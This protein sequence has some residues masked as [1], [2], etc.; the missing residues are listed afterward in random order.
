MCRRTAS[1]VIGLFLIGLA[2]SPAVAQDVIMTVAGTGVV[3][4]A[5]DGGQATAAQ[6]NSPRGVAVDSAGNVYISDF[7]AHCVRKIDATTGVV[8]TVAGTGVAGYNG[9]GIAA[10]AA[11]LNSPAGM[12]LDGSGNLFIADRGNH[13]IRVVS[14]SSGRIATVAGTGTAGY[15]GDGAVATSKQLYY[16]LGVAVDG[17]G[18][19]YIADFNNHRIRKVTYSTGFIST[20]AGT[21]TAGYTGDGGQATLAQI[22]RPRRVALDASGN[23]FI[24]DTGNHCVRKV[25]AS[26][27]VIST[28]AGT[29]VAGY[30]GDGIAATA[31]QLNAPVEMALDTLG[32]LYIA[33]SDNNRIRRVDWAVHQ[34]STLAGTG[35]AG[36]GGD[37]GPATGAA[38]NT[39]QGLAMSS[40]GAVGYTFYIAD[41]ANARVRRVTSGGLITGAVTST[42]GTP[43][44]GVTLFLF[45][46]TGVVAD[47]TGTNAAGIYALTHVPAGTYYLMTAN[48]LGYVDE[49]YDNLACYGGA[50]PNPTTGTAL[51]VTNGTATTGKDVAL[52]QAGAISGTVTNA[53]SSAPLSGVSVFAYSAANEQLVGV[54]TNASGQYTIE[55]LPARTYYLKTGNSL[56]YIDEVYNNVP[57][58]L[59]V[60]PNPSTGTAVTV[61]AGVTAGGRDLA[62]TPG[63]TIAGSVTDEMSGAPLASGFVYFY[64]AGGSF[65]G[66]AAIAGGA[67]TRTLLA[68]GT[69]YLKTNNSLGYVDEVYNNLPC[70]GGSCPPVTGGTGVTVGTG[71][72]QGGVNFGLVR[73][74]TITG[75]VTAAATGS[76]IQGVTA[77]VYNSAGATV[78]SSATNSSGIYSVP[79]LTP[80]TYY[81]KTNN[82]SGYVDELFDNLPC[83]AGTCTPTSGTP[84]VL[85]GNQ[86]TNT[87]FALET[88]GTITGT[89]TAAG[90]GA[91]IS[92]TTIY[93]SSTGGWA[94]TATTDASGHYSR[95]GLPAGTYYVKTL[96]STGYLNELYDNIQCEYGNCV[97]TS[98]TPVAVT[99]GATRAGVDFALAVGG[100]I[101]GTVTAEGTGLPLANVRVWTSNSAG[102][103][104]GYATTNAS[105]AYTIVG[106]ATGAHYVYT[107]NTLGYVDE[108]YDGI[109]CPGSSCPRVD[110]GTPVSVTAGSAS[111]PV[112]FSLAPGGFIAG[113]VSAAGTTTKLSNVLAYVLDAAGTRVATARTDASGVY[114]TTAMPAGTYYVV[115]HNTQGYVD[116]LFNDVPCPGS[117]SCEAASGSQVN[118]AIGQTAGGID[119]ALDRGGTIAGTVTGGGSPLRL[120]NVEVYDAGGTLVGAGQ[121][122]TSGAYETT[123]LPAGSYHV[124][125]RNRL[126]YIDEV[127]EELPCVGGACPALGGGAGV[128]VVVGAA[129]A[130][131]FDLAQGGT[132]AGGVADGRTGAPLADITLHVHAAGGAEVASALSDSTGNYSVASLP[133]GTYYVRTSNSLGYLDLLYSNLPCPGG[134]CT[135]TAGTPIT[136][137]AGETAGGKDFWLFRTGG[138]D[139]TGDGTSDLLWR[140]SGGDLWL[141]GIAQ[142]AHATDAYVG[143]VSDPNWEIRAQGDFDGDGKADLLWRHKLDGTVYYWKMNGPT[144]AAELYVSTVDVSY[145]IAGTGDF[146]GDG[147]ADVLWRNPAIGDLW[148]WRMNGA[149]V[150]GQVY[151]DTVDLSY[152]IKGLGDLNGDLKTDVVWQ[153]AAGD[154]W[155]WLMNGAA[156]SSVAYVGTVADGTYQIQA[157]VDFDADAKADLLWW[158]SV[159]GDVWIWRMNGASVVSEH[160]VGLVADTNYRVQSAGDYNGDGKADLLWRNIV[161]GDLWVWLMNGPTKAS[162][163]YLGIVAD[164][165]YQVVR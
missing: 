86:V 123:G 128:A 114:A 151:V 74:G 126:G 149:A 105:G 116:E 129:T 80:G 131:D 145:D 76:P 81:V 133:A 127:Y 46:P 88:G 21:G 66:S 120:V 143:V 71:T 122:S 109:A 11:Q 103:T 89:V 5:G 97:M 62:L 153:G 113:T 22:Y 65:L 8:T 104:A 90:S 57:C 100:T 72:T 84:I 45:K 43:L 146:D 24:A 137:A 98:G 1:I 31:A 130:L 7:S 32:N 41:G 13:R 50:C 117:L 12:A 30:N 99:A 125:T 2:A 33:D 157:V 138:G 111:G 49:V 93:I 158:N 165:G 87:S 147:K 79:G 68:A 164:Q 161:G 110:N 40:A 17:S 58:P 27:G 55:A 118:V 155:A 142:A 92:G 60:C 82:T 159:A 52:A 56:G 3:G 91:L 53:A 15:D 67:Y 121:S 102:S 78:A 150:L 26:T 73:G 61:V 9:D 19:L 16:P 28:V 96:N 144:P 134:A 156:K 69:Y 44:A 18:N 124:R 154:L 162:E 4:Y 29:G 107:Y 94:T 6:L 23:L 85:T 48:T 36:F 39:P 101:S 70:P 54:T 141:W 106:L 83:P 51:T 34:I 112:D 75:T 148:L 37:G 59:G 160:Y 163:V 136:I 139:F 63:S 152:A 135:A 77:W 64:N 119:F 35:E 10:T 25:L 95:A 14:A 42:T 132:I 115:T 20:V 140:G 38:L 47:L 108:L